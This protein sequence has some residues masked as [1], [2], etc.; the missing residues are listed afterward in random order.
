MAYLIHYN[1]NHSKTNGQFISGDGD[2][3]GIANDHANQRKMSRNEKANAKFESGK[4]SFWNKGGRA[5]NGE[6]QGFYRAKNFLDYPYYIDSKGGKHYY[7]NVFDLPDGE[8]G[9]AYLQNL[10]KLLLLPVAEVYAIKT[11]VGDYKSTKG[12]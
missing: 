12:E 6:T 3:D 1:K 11:M 8:K 5:R 4:E 9:R 10:G 7:N 2:G